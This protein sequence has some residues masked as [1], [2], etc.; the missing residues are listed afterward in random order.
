MIDQTVSHHRVV[1]KRDGDISV[2]CKAEDIRLSPFVAFK[3]LSED[4]VRD[5]RILAA[6]KRGHA[7]IFGCAR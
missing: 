4:V 1:E 3:S 2:V 5:P 6:F 7:R